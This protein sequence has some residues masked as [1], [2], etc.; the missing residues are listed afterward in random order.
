M[1][2][3]Y[4]KR[5]KSSKAKKVETFAVP[6]SLVEFKENIIVCTN[7]FSEFS[8]EELINRIYKFHS[9]GNILEAKKYYT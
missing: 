8:K 6:H 3:Y 2:E 4:N 1:N 5:V 7:E 9:E